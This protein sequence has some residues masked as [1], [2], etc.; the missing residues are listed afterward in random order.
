MTDEAT[1]HQPTGIHEGGN[2]ELPGSVLAKAKTGDPEAISTL[3]AQF[4]DPDEAVHSVAYFGVLGIGPFGTHSF[5]CST[6]RRVASLEVGVFGR[7]VYQDGFLEYVTSGVLYQPSLLGLVIM[8][9]FG[10][11]FAIA[12][13]G[14]GLLLFPIL[15]KA[16]YRFNK[17]GLVYVI[18]DGVSV[19]MFANRA[20]IRRANLMYRE[21]AGLRERRRDLLKVH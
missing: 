6:D 1:T 4:I 7:V 13:F 9:I 3:F 20:L 16:Y 19:Y 2:L 11:I 8:M 12:T 17:S 5:A 15:I 10:V 18:Q 14:L 21:V